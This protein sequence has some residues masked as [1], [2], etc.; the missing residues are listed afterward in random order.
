MRCILVGKRNLPQSPRPTRDAS[1][2][3]CCNCFCQPPGWQKMLRTMNIGWKKSVSLF[4][5]YAKAKVFINIVQG[6][7]S[8]TWGKFWIS[9]RLYTKSRLFCHTNLRKHQETKKTTSVFVGR[10][11]PS[12][13]I[14]L[15]NLGGFHQLSVSSPSGLAPSMTPSHWQLW[16]HNEVN[17]HG[18]T[19]PGNEV[20]GWCFFSVISNRITAIHRPQKKTDG[21]KTNMG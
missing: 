19:A 7:V 3:S 11:Y 8:N 10:S 17:L 18:F 20:Q 9:S 5:V 14:Y 15:K 12:P 16:L 1:D 2:C 4:W 13:Q 6:N 21:N